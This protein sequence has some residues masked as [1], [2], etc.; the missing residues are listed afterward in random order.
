MDFDWDTV[1]Q[2]VLLYREHFRKQ[3]LFWNMGGFLCS[4]AVIASLALMA[5]QGQTLWERYGT[6]GLMPLISMAVFCVMMLM[7]F[8]MTKAVQHRLACITER[9][10]WEY[11]IDLDADP[12]IPNGWTL[13]S[14]QKGGGK[15]RWDPSEFKLF[16]P[17][18]N[19]WGFQLQRETKGQNVWNANLLDWFLANPDCIPKECEGKKT[20]FIGT[21]YTQESDNFTTARYL[22][23]R[24]GFGRW[25]SGIGIFVPLNGPVAIRVD[26]NQ[27]R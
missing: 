15:F 16:D 27:W 23:K 18:Y 25:R 2:D 12:F 21:L 5:P 3:C 6:P 11:V 17:G 1:D 4:I 20:L 9:K 24:F 19:R 22:Y 13:A 14:H 8:W 26:K 10:E 7:S